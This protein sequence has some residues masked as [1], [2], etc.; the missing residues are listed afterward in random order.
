MKRFVV[1]L[2]LVYFSLNAEEI[3]VDTKAMTKA[4]N[5][6]RK[7]Y[8]SPPLTYSKDLE[9]AAKKWAVRLQAD[10]CAMVHSKGA[11]GPFGENLYWASAFKKA[12]AKD[13][14]GNWIWQRSLQDIDEAAVVQA[15]YDEVQWYDYATNSCD[16]GEMCGHYT[17]VVWNTTKELGCA[18]VACDDR[19]QVWVCEYAP[20]GNLS[21]RH[22]SGKVEKL[23][24]Y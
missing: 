1:V 8:D 14:K 12:D 24:P 20:A 3:A 6:L 23:R 10:G 17:Q 9:N 18:A 16:Q 7:K 5:D 13:E 11:V 2:V 15:W 19:S 4:H 21:I 22:A